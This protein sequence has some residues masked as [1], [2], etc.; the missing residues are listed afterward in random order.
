MIFFNNIDKVKAKP[1]VK[2]VGG[3]SQMIKSL[4]P[5]LKRPYNKF[6]EPF[7]G[8]GAVFFY[9]TPQNGI[10]CDY[11][12]ELISAYKVIKCKKHL[13]LLIKELN[14]NFLPFSNK[15][16]EYYNIRSQNFNDKIKNTARFIY[17]NKSCFNGIYRVNKSGEFNVPFGKNTKPIILNEDN[18]YKCN[19]VLKNTKILCGDFYKTLKYIEKDD[20]IYLDPPYAP[21]SKTAN[22][23]QYTKKDFKE[24]DQERLREYCEEIMKKKAKFILNNSDVKLIREL[25]GNHKDILIT[26]T[27]IRRMLGAD[28]KS[29][30]LVNELIITNI[31]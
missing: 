12:K 25:Y 1:F 20:L 18:L 27:K 24:F 10:I 17:L 26:P 21:L 4:S 8:G 13:K 6:I 29:R 11:N 22:F 9:K 15:E 30:I 31:K 5:F 16:K 7:V 3:K 28:K 14:D 19:E 2:W 23:T